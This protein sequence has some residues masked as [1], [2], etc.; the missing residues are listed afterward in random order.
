M[1]FI[2]YDAR[3]H[4][5]GEDAS[6]M[7]TADDEKETQNHNGDYGDDCL[8]YEYEFDGKAATNGKPRHG[9]YKNESGTN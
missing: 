5:I 4:S 8:W 9:L 3:A 6:I 1:K 2:L 7:V